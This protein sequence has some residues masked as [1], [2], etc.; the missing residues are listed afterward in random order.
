M[1]LELQWLWKK[2]HGALFHNLHPWISAI[3]LTKNTVSG[4][5][6]IQMH[7]HTH[8]QC[9]IS[10]LTFPPF[11][12][13]SWNTSEEVIR[14]VN[15]QKD[16]QVY[17]WPLKMTN[18]T[19]KKVLYTEWFGFL[20]RVAEGKKASSLRTWFLTGPEKTWAIV[21]SVRIFFNRKAV[22][23]LVLE[24]SVIN[25]SAQTLLFER[26]LSKTSHEIL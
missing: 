26:T 4:Y 10:A 22:F 25:G 2:L 6:H 12:N 23:F 16:I 11:S 21:V 9:K 1:E 17:K 18:G 24:G 15:D 14:N 3:E 7:T 5:M 13:F 8:T 20:L 19:R